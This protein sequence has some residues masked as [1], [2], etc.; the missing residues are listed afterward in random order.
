MNVKINFVIISILKGGISDSRNKV[1]M[2]M[3]NMIGIGERAGSGVPDIYSVWKNQGWIA[4]QVIEEYLP[5]RT[6]LKLSFVRNEL[7]NGDRKKVTEK[8]QRQ[9]EFILSRMQ[10]DMEYKV[11]EVAQW[12][13]VGRTRARTLLKMLIIDGKILETGTTK[14][15]RY[16]RIK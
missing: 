13:D 1:L 11:T 2:K 15:K 16:Q 10:P 12:L 3:F 7:K 14:M 4:P 9:K 6:I 5:D 8:T